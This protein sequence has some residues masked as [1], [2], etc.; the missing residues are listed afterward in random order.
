MPVGVAARATRRDAVA[1]PAEP[2]QTTTVARHRD[3]SMHDSI[4][5]QQNETFQ[6]LMLGFKNFGELQQSCVRFA[7]RHT[8]KVRL[9]IKTKSIYALFIII[10]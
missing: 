1:S 8:K 9:L 10:F 5:V 7:N 2:R 4:H 3:T 6:Y